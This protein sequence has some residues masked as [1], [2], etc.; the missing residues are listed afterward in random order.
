MKQLL[1]FLCLTL[2]HAICFAQDISIADEQAVQTMTTTNSLNGS[3]I[4]FENSTPNPGPFPGSKK[5]GSLNY[6]VGSAT[7]GQMS[8]EVGGFLSP[9]RLKFRIGGSEVMELRDTGLFTV[10]VLE[11]NN[12]ARCSEGGLWLSSCS[13]DFKDLRSIA[14]GSTV[15]NQIRKLPVY[16]WSYK[17]HPSDMHIG[18]T[19]EDFHQAFQIG[20]DK[21]IAGVDMGGVALAAIQELLQRIEMLEARLESREN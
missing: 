15:L 17:G 3:V 5:I 6:K 4:V 16:N 20:D 1:F 11:L 12:G 19:A 18:P 9:D 14:P 21:S 10:N 7:R 13:R 2:I 8:Y